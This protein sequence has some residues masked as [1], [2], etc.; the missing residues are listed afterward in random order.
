MGKLTS[1]SI[2][3]LSP[4][5]MV[6]VAIGVRDLLDCKTGYSFNKKEMDIPVP[7]LTFCPKSSG[8]PLQSD[9]VLETFGNGSDLPINLLITMADGIR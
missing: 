5:F 8:K 4:I 2:L 3:I 9:K 1:L 7:S 6:M